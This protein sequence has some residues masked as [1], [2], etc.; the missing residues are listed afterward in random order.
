LA[1]LLAKKIR[2]AKFCPEVGKMRASFKKSG[3]LHFTLA[4]P[5]MGK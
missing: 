2:I 5:T 3:L 4:V 1:L